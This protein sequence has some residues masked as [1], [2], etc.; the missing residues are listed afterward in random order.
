[1]NSIFPVFAAKSDI[2]SF[3]VY[4]FLSAYLT[5]SMYLYLTPYSIKFNFVF[6][7]IPIKFLAVLHVCL[8]NI[9][10]VGLNMRK[11]LDLNLYIEYYFY[12]LQ[13]LG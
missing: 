6:L 13:K 7:P 8:K 10:L 2:L 4:P 3:K 11:F 1:M 12:F 5:M 9:Y